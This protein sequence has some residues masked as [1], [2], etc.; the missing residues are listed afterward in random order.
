MGP[1]GGVSFHNLDTDEFFS[2]KINDEFGR[3]EIAVPPGRYGLGIRCY[4]YLSD[5]PARFEVSEAGRQ[6]YV[7]TLQANFFA[8]QSL[9]SA[10][11]TT[12]GGV[13]PMPDTDFTVVDEWEWTQAH[14]IAPAA[15][16]MLPERHIM[17]LSGPR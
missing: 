10:W 16:G 6:Y 7:G 13:I 17:S 1:I 8:R 9:G 2:Y 15:N 5:T 14:R 12:F 11:A 3:F 4:I